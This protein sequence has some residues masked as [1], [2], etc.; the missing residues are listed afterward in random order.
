MKMD[1]NDFEKLKPQV[2]GILTDQE[3]REP[4]TN[5]MTEELFYRSQSK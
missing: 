4:E 2:P 3:K 1:Q 5:I